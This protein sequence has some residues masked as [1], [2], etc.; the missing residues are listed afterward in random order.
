MTR[1]VANMVGANPPTPPS[2]I[3]EESIKTDINIRREGEKE[4][5][6]ERERCI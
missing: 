4:R 1:L 2:P 6:G 5:M 3:S